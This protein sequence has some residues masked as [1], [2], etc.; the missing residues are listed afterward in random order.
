MDKIIQSFEALFFQLITISILLPK[1]IWKTFNPYFSYCYITNQLALE[2]KDQ[3][4]DNVSP[5]LL[6]LMVVVLPIY[7][8]LHTNESNGFKEGNV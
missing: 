1:T 5:V 2:S 4:K 3:F 7:L 8:F 6:F